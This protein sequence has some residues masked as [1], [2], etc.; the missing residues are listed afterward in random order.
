[1]RKE[2]TQLYLEWKNR[3][4]N[5]NKMNYSYTYSNTNKYTCVN[6][7]LDKQIHLFVYK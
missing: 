4:L 3:W 1:M 5:N 7:I 2:Q 6:T